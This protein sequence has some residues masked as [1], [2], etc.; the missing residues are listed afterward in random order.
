MKSIL[1]IDEVLFNNNIEVEQMKRLF[2]GRYVIDQ[3]LEE[4]K[5][6]LRENILI[7][8]GD[9][10]QI[11][12]YK[13]SKI[14]FINIELFASVEGNSTTPIDYLIDFFKTYKVDEQFNFDELSSIDEIISSMEDD[15]K[16][17]RIRK[18]EIS[19]TENMLEEKYRRIIV[20]ERGASSELLEIVG[21]LSGN[22]AWEVLM[23]LGIEK[24]HKNKSSNNDDIEEIL[25]Y[26]Y[27]NFQVSKSNIKII[28][29]DVGYDS[30][31]ERIDSNYLITLK[32]VEKNTGEVTIIIW[33][34]KYGLK[35]YTT[36]ISYK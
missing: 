2:Y 16:L 7:H 5:E 14:Q 33:D 35:N 8:K 32:Y 28:D 20:F 3:G 27:D 29:I 26:A 1:I 25:D 12:I 13:Y 24:I 36:G 9:G 19:I 34:K 30:E 22:I 21:W 17:Y 11:Y 18:N 4:L 6:N 10:F 15:R 23:N 31:K